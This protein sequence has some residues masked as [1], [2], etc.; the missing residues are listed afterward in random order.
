MAS[1]YQK[2]AATTDGH[3]QC[4]PDSKLTW[5]NDDGTKA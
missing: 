5:F 1:A 3:A 2:Y 4:C